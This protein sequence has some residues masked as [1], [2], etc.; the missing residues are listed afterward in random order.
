MCSGPKQ[1]QSRGQVPIA[2]ISK[3][4]NSSVILNTTQAS[5][6]APVQI[7]TNLNNDA[8]KNSNEEELKRQ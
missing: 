6:S 8:N 7:D 3:S 2:K 1:D 4:T 5:I